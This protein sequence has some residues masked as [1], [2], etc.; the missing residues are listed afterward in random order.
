MLLPTPIIMDTGAEATAYQVLGA[1][2]DFVTGGIT[3]RVGLY[4][5]QAS[6]TAQRR[7]LEVRSV[8]CDAQ[9]AAAVVGTQNL[10]ALAQAL[11]AAREPFAAP[12]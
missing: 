8:F 11:I 10:S 9:A 12:A 1:D 2:R 7:P 3:V 5:D 4:L 6:A